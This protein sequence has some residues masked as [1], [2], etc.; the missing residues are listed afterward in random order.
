MSLTAFSLTLTV[1]C[2]ARFVPIV[3]DLAAHAVAYAEMDQTL[4]SAFVGHVTT[5]SERDSARGGHLAAYEVR[6][7]CEDGELRV[8][9][10]SETLRQR[11]A[12]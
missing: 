2:D 7:T 4:G 8:S 12:A 3:R 9:M 10:G 11:I 6:F 5:T 1:P